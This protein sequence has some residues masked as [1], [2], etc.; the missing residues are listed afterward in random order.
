MPIESRLDIR[1]TQ[2]LILTP[3]L[4]QAIKLLQMQK[5][6][7]VEALNQEL[8]ENPF[9]E[10][11]NEVTDEPISAEAHDITA[12]E[13]E[14]P[15][16]R[17]LEFSV[18]EY[19]E[20]RASDGRDLGYF[21][22]GTVETPSFEKFVSRKPDLAEHL[23]W[24]LM[25]SHESEEVKKAGEIIIGNIDENGYLRASIEELIALSGLPEEVVRKAVELIQTFDPPGVGARDLKECLLIQARY[26]GLKDSLVEKIILN[27]LDDLEKKR[28]INIAKQ[29]NVSIDEVNQAVKIIQGFDPKPGRNYSSQEPTYVEP[30]VFIIK[31]D[32]EYRIILNDDGVPRFRLNE[33]Y[34]QL[35]M[36]KAQLTKEERQ[37][38]EDKLRSAMW[39][40]KS[41]DQR[42]RTIY[43][44]TESI[45]NFQREFFDRGVDY[46]KPLTLRQVAKELGMHESTISRVTSNKFLACPHGI[47][48]F[49]FFFSSALQGDSGEVSSTKVKELIKKIISEEDPRNPLSD[50][51]IVEILKNSNIHIARRTVSKYRTEL[52]ILSQNQRKILE[53][54]EEL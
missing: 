51:Q 33:K 14:S 45:L 2:K 4:Q 30:D 44:V 23:Q 38:L 20:E 15:L 22:P 24:Q 46:L 3:Q 25:L 35:L 36:N 42:N 52:K 27:N 9:L 13:T 1:L 11:L 47:F 41:L 7:L 12:E 19:F 6:E 34:R 37:F 16:E 43:R 48:P 40:I 17:L 29:Y 39:L 8:I 21:N 18:D 28:F 54:K 50:Q 31:D 10:E 5:L 53:K 49:R 26:L 32:E